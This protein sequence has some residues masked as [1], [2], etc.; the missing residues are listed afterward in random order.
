[1]TAFQ[2]TNPVLH[3]KDEHCLRIVYRIIVTLISVLPKENL[4]NR[5]QGLNIIQSRKVVTLLIAQI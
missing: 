2:G 4:F 1:M 5:L 3:G